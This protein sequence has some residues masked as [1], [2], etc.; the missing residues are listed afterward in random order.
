MDIV[1]ESLHAEVR[2]LLSIQENTRESGW[3]QV[4]QGLP[5][6]AE[7]LA[8]CAVVAKVCSSDDCR[9][10]HALQDESVASVLDK[11]TLD[12]MFNMEDDAVSVA[13]MLDGVCEKA[14]QRTLPSI[15]SQPCNK[16]MQRVYRGQGTRQPSI[17]PR[18]KVAGVWF[19]RTV[20]PVEQLRCI[21]RC[22]ELLV[23]AYCRIRLRGICS[24]QNSC[25]R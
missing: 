17:S 2:A 11:A 7:K 21:L 12:T 15:F 23:V 22:T 10:C 13:K 24:A 16:Y 4:N 18:C 19:F 8:T 25:K 9:R 20:F 14:N 6:Y 3:F 5:Y 1:P